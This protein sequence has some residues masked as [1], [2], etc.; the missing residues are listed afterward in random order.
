[1]TN[2]YD[3]INWASVGKSALIGAATGAVFGGAL[4]TLKY[5]LTASVE[6][7]K[8][9]LQTA[10]DFLSTIPNISRGGTIAANRL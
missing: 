7:A 8:A 1:L 3:N 6:A 4:N 10:D 9:S 5:S 2:G